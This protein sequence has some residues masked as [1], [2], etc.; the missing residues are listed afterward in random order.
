MIERS[1]QFE[2]PFDKI[3]QID[4]DG[5]EYW[6]G[7]DI[8]NVL[9]YVD[10]R[11]M[12]A[13]CRDVYTSLR[14]ENPDQL[15]MVVATKGVKF[16]R[17][18]IRIVPDWKL[19]RRALDLLIQRTASRKPLASL[20]LRYQ[21]K[22]NFRIETDFGALLIDFCRVLDIPLIHQKTIDNYRYDFCIG[23]D[24]LLEIDEAHH[25]IGHQ[26][27]TDEHKDMVAALHGYKLLRVKTT[28]EWTASM[29]FGTLTNMLKSDFVHISVVKDL[30][31][32]RLDEE[33]RR[34]RVLTPQD[35][36]AFDNAG[37]Q[38]LYNGLTEREIIER[39]ELDVSLPLLD[40]IGIEELA[41]NLFRIS[42]T[43]A[44]LSR[45]GITDKAAARWIHRQVSLRIRAAI[46]ESGNM[47]PEDLPVEKYQAAGASGTK[48][49]EFADKKWSR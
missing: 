29:L 49:T 39:K 40:Q 43:Q 33:M 9:D 14:M 1:D 18:A 45:E 8:A 2:S 28:A 10:W 46:A 17:G 44:V 3:R 47:M 21:Q 7:R 24:I 32:S 6:S 15:D 27:D 37:Y 38:A 12:E 31:Q 42:E 19:S 41:S 35:R 11:N 30:V 25:E 34:L 26:P 4:S 5:A 36:A 13:V 48:A 20:M 16:G 22:S 23:D